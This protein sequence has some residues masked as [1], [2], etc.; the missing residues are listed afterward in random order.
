MTALKAMPFRA[1]G[2]RRWPGAL[3]PLALASMLTACNTAPT[4][5]EAIIEVPTAYKEAAAVQMRW[6][7]GQSAV[8][9]P[10]GQWWRAFGDPSLDKLQ[11]QAEAGSP[12]LVTAAARVKAA[13]ALLQGAES[14]RVP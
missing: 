4:L 7:A 9:Q 1:A 14:G 3:V 6:K 10:E 2:Q 5:P 13:R 11:R 8:P 12:G